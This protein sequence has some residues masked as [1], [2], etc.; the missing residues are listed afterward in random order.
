MAVILGRFSNN[1]HL[2]SS[3]V[4]ALLDSPG[5]IFSLCL[6][7]IGIFQLIYSDNGGKFICIIPDVGA[8]GGWRQ[9]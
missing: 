2:G 9:V 3:S 5:A 8:M 1:N 7:L 6:S 4:K